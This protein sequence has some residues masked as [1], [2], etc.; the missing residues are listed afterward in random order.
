MWPNGE[1][2]SFEMDPLV[3]A[4]VTKLIQNMWN[5]FLPLPLS[6]AH[7]FSFN[8]VFEEKTNPEQQQ[9]LRT[10]STPTHSLLPSFFFFFFLFASILL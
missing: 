5:S 4:F 2:G 10:N 6:S 8:F 3:P 1:N 9:Q 7:L